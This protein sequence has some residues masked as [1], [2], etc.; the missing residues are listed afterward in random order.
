VVEEELHCA[1]ELHCAAADVLVAWSTMMSS[2]LLIHRP[3]LLIHIIADYSS[4][5][6]ISEDA[7][8]PV[9]LYAEFFMVGKDFVCNGIC[10]RKQA[11]MKFPEGFKQHDTMNCSSTERLDEIQIHLRGRM[12]RFSV[13]LNG[14]MGCFLPSGPAAVRRFLGDCGFGEARLPY[15]MACMQEHHKSY[16]CML[17]MK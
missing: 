2:S 10:I 12:P 6:S 1:Q 7:M 16:A 17:C 15:L 13:G 3:S 5:P 4:L 11:I 9:P 8:R 14:M